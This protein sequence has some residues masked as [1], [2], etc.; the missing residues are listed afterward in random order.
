MKFCSVY[1]TEFHKYIGV[2]VRDIGY[3]FGAYKKIY[4]NRKAIYDSRGIDL[5]LL[6][7]LKF[8]RKW[9]YLCK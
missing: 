8:N 9:M 2:V 4:L 7:D 5:K 3:L 1:M 6:K